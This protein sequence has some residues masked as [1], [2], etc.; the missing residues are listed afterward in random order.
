MFALGPLIMDGGLP[1]GAQRTAYV[2]PAGGGLEGRAPSSVWWTM[3]PTVVLGVPIGLG[4]AVI[5]RVMG[6]L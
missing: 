1:R 3:L 6:R 5:A 2:I 4:L